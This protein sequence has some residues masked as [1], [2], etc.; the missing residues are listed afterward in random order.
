MLLG[1]NNNIHN[2][3]KVVPYW[4]G[5]F[6]GGI[7]VVSRRKEEETDPTQKAERSAKGASRL[8][9]MGLKGNRGT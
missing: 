4:I 2:T 1:R 6:I 3:F 9:G 8:D 5:F 7:V